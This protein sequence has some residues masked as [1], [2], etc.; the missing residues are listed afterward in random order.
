MKE[1][2]R[3]RKPPKIAILIPVLDV[4]CPTCRAAVGQLCDESVGPRLDRVIRDTPSHFHRLE[5]L[6]AEIRRLEAQES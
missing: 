2:R 4:A 1:Q 3:K 6:V 5:A